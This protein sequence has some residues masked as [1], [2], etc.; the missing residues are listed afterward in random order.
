MSIK[1]SIILDDGGPSSLD[2]PGLQ[3]IQAHM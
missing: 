1:I 3:P 2:A